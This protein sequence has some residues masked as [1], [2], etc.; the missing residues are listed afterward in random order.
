MEVHTMTPMNFS[1]EKLKETENKTVFIAKK[2]S[3]NR[4]IKVDIGNI[5]R[6]YL[7]KWR[8]PNRNQK[9]IW[10]SLILDEDLE[11]YEQFERDTII[12]SDS[13]KMKPLVAIL[14]REQVRIHSWRYVPINPEIKKQ[15]GTLYIP[16]EIMKGE[17]PK[18]IAIII[19]WSV[20]EI[21]ISNECLYA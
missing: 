14:K 16:N 1:F 18:K 3:N 20:Q 6:A 2:D 12:E 7:S 9:K 13:D 11:L 8:I 10:V 17:W 21:N 15:I 19:A 5:F 4:D